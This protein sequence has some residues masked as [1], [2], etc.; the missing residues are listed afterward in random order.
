MIVFGTLQTIPPQVVI[1]WSGWWVQSFKNIGSIINPPSQELGQCLKQIV[2][3]D[4][5]TSWTPNP[6]PNPWSVPQW[7]SSSLV[8]SDVSTPRDVSRLWETFWQTWPVQRLS[9]SFSR[10]NPFGSAFDFCSSWK[11]RWWLNHNLLE[12]TKLVGQSSGEKDRIGR[13]GLKKAQYTGPKRSREAKG[14]HQRQ[15][16]GLWR[17]RSSGGTNLLGDREWIIDPWLAVYSMLIFIIWF[18]LSLPLGDIGIEAWLFI[19][20]WRWLWIFF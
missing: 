4:N 10:P 7:F 9:I 6:N 15:R 20:C 19:V 13:W 16:L 1:R 17:I 12:S 18:L 14:K 8:S 11:S 3:L 5:Y 2:L